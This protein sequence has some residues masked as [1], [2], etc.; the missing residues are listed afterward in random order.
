MDV[1]VTCRTRKEN[2]SAVHQSALNDTCVTATGDVIVA[3]PNSMVAAPEGKVTGETA[4]GDMLLLPA[5]K[6]AG[7]LDPAAPHL[8]ACVYIHITQ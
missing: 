3:V 2:L 8:A 7:Q 1:C 5:V 6:D 4:S